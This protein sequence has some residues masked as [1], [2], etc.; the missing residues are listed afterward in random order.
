MTLKVST[1]TGTLYVVA[2]IFA[3]HGF[4]VSGCDTEL[5]FTVDLVEVFFSTKRGF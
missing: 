3:F 1:A 4:T 5:N 2:G